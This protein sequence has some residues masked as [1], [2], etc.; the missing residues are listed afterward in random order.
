MVY[1]LMPSCDLPS[2]SISHIFLSARKRAGAVSRMVFAMI[3]AS[4]FLSSAIPASYL[5]CR[6]FS[7]R[8]VCSHCRLNLMRSTFA[9]VESASISA[10]VAGSGMG[11]SAM[12]L[13]TPLNPINEGGVVPMI[14]CMLS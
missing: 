4:W 2:T 7:A 1:I 6:P 8:S 5:C 12:V 11:T 10:C 3:D 14:K 9:F 13:M